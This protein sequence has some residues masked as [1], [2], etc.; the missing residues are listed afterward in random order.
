MSS[1]RERIE[2]A[3]EGL[4]VSWSEA[5]DGMQTLNVGLAEVPQLAELLQKACAFEIC[6]L[7]TAT[8]HYPQTPRFEMVWQLQSVTHSD[9]VRL[10]AFAEASGEDFNAPSLT[11]LWPGAAYLERE[12]F[13]LLGI[14]FTGHKDFRERENLRRILMP[15]AFAH[16][17]LRKDFPHQGIEPDKLYKLWDAQ[18]RIA[19]EGIAPE[20]IAPEGAAPEQSTVQEAEPC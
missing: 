19:P 9:R 16:H 14:T 5:A 3:L 15:G 6:T 17:P 18:R 8:D 1:T 2:A 7:I 4:E 13:D 20:S 11:H 12:C 10:H